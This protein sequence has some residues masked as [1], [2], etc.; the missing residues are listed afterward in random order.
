M[1]FHDANRKTRITCTIS[2]FLK[3]SV[4]S[5]LGATLKI[6]EKIKETRLKFSQGSITAL[7]KMANY[8]KTRVKLIN[9][10]LNKLK[11]VAKNKG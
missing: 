7:K 8:D 3:T 4:F 6:L 11:S 5:T 9:S 10:Q 1:F 2:T